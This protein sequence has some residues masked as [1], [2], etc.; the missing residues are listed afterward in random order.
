MTYI[1]LLSDPRRGGSLSTFKK[2]VS[3]FQKTSHFFTPSPRGGVCTGHFLKVTFGIKINGHG[4]LF[5]GK[6]W[7]ELNFPRH[8]GPKSTTFTRNLECFGS[9][10]MV[11]KENFLKKNLR[12]LRRQV[13]LPFCAHPTPGGR[14]S[15]PKKPVTHFQKKPVSH[16][17]WGVGCAL[18]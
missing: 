8:V 5:W 4:C 10:L 14:G 1:P 15:W 3:H 11:K 16:H 2:P 12:R 13:I 6:I 17:P 9:F 7:C 18:H